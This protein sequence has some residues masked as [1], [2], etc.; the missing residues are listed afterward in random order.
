MIGK[1]YSLHWINLSNLCGRTKRSTSAHAQNT[2][3]A[4]QLPHIE[5]A[6]TLSG[7]DDINSPKSSGMS[8][9]SFLGG[10]VFKNHFKPGSRFCLITLT[11]CTILRLFNI[12]AN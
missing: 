9:C 6:S 11:S 8:Y 10:E 2:S 12:G 3:C 7:C 4:D 1:K 5:Q